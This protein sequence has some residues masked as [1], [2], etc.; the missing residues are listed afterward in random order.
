MVTLLVEAT[1]QYLSLLVHHS[2]GSSF[3]GQLMAGYDDGL[4]ACTDHEI[5]IRRYYI[6]HAKRISYAA[7]REVRQVPLSTTRKIRIHGSGD[8]VHWFNHDP[9]RRRKELA[10]VI[11]L[12]D[13]IRPVITPDDPAQVTAE[14][15]AHG[16]NITSGPETGLYEKQWSDLSKR[17]RGLIVVA[18]VAAVGLLTAAFVDITRRPAGQI[19]GSKRIWTAAVLIQQPFGPLSY[20]AFGRRRRPPARPR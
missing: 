19:R 8:G 12:D 2:Q 5:V 3:G 16:V 13:K 20:F 11:Y 18:G 14:L 17:S 4:V 1:Q 10:L 9:D 7:I 15:A 6:R